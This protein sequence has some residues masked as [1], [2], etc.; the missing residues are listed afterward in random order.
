MLPARLRRIGERPRSVTVHIK[1]HVRKK[2]HKWEG[3]RKRKGKGKGY[4]RLVELILQ[5]LAFWIV[6]SS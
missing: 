2:G 6:A 4:S 3:E 5:S 1:L